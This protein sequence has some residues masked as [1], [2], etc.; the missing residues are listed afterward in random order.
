[1]T[2]LCWLLTQA[3]ALPDPNRIPLPCGN[4]VSQLR[5]VRCNFDCDGFKVEVLF[6]RMDGVRA[7]GYVLQTEGAISFCFDCETKHTSKR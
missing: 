2:V 7:G 3:L 6:L 1:M 5:S 4:D